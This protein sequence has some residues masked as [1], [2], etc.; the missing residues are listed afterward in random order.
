M[1]AFMMLISVA[2]IALSIS[3]CSDEKASTG[4]GAKP[5]EGKV[6][7]PEV[8]GVFWVTEEAANSLVALDAR[9]GKILARVTNIPTPHNV[10]ATAD[11]KTVW[12]TSG[13]SNQA[14]IIDSKTLRLIATIA[15]GDH[16]A[17]V[18]HSPDSSRTVVVAA[19]DGVVQLIDNPDPKGVAGSYANQGEQPSMFVIVTPVPVGEFPHG[20]R[21]SPDGKSV[22]VANMQDGTI[23]IVRVANARMKDVDPSSDLTASGARETRTVK[24]GGTPVQ[25]AYSPDA[26]HLFVTLNED[27]EVARINLATMKVDG[28]AKTGLGPIQIFVT[29]DGKMVLVAVQGTKERP[30]KSLMVFDAGTMKKISTVDTAAGTHGVMVE[31]GGKLAA[32][33]NTFADSVQYIDLKT[34]KVVVTTD[35]GSEPNGVSFTSTRPVPTGAK[36][37]DG[38]LTVKM[39]LVKKAPETP[40]KRSD[41]HDHST[42]DHGDSNENG[43]VDPHGH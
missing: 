7:L 39:P 40:E 34:M 37:V 14:Y 6:T 10:E 16:P 2:L 31:P 42:H 43:E 18:T 24:V 23:S 22:A 26:K 35:V 11:G 36:K 15:A 12:A 17:H 8:N 28:R 27:N 32:V 9:T 4:K 30:S 5:G 21:F 29:P 25:V 3:A 1:R 13:D 41:K 20:A 19:G 33:T 38:V